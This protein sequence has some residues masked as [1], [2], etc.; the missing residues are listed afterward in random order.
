MKAPK[1][2]AYERFVEEKLPELQ[3]Q[4]EVDLFRHGDE[5]EAAKRMCEHIE[6]RINH[7]SARKGSEAL[8]RLI[9]PQ[10]E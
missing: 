8:V 1:S 2:D 4:M 6:K 5:V 3:W 7:P 9:K 10:E